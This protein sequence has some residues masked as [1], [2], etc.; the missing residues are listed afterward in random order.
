MIH[1]KTDLLNEKN[2]RKQTLRIIN[3]IIK[4]FLIFCYLAFVEYSFIYAKT[5]LI[6]T[7]LNSQRKKDL[8]KEID[9]KFGRKLSLENKGKYV[10]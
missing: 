8:E 3:R 1:L 4:R 5:D 9:A 2:K 10:S 7:Q 6:S